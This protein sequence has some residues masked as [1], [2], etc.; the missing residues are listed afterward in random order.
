[1]SDVE[2]F[3]K[4]NPKRLNSLGEDFKTWRREFQEDEKRN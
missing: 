1:M 3:A 2:F 4:L